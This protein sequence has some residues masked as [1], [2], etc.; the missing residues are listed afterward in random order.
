MIERMEGEKGKLV[1][2]KRLMEKL[3]F[4]IDLLTYSVEGGRKPQLE[5][6]RSWHEAVYMSSLQH[7]LFSL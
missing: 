6:S 3:T 2:R 7:K 4:V 1:V 5:G